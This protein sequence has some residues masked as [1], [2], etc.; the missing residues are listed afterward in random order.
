VYLFRRDGQEWYQS[1]KFSID[2]TVTDDDDNFGAGIAV[3]D[4]IALIGAPGDEYSSEK[5]LFQSPEK[6][7]RSGTVYIYRRENDEWVHQKKIVP[8]HGDPENF[9]APISLADNTALIGSI[10]TSS[11]WDDEAMSMAYVFKQIS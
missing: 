2:G 8:S 6:R 10:D 7:G 5:P 4:N 11:Q 9:G 1:Q 3:G